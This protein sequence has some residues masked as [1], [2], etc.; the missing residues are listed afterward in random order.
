MREAEKRAD[1]VPSTLVIAA[2]IRPN[3]HYSVVLSRVRPS[4]EASLG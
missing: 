1:M 3:I 2:A 4:I